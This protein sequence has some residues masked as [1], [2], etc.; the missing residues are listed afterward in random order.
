MSLSAFDPAVAGYWIMM[1]V[2][3]IHEV[4]PVFRF[5]RCLK[6][7]VRFDEGALP[8]GIGFTGN[9]LGLFVLVPFRVDETQAVQQLSDPA[10]A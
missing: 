6:L 4:N 7:T 3:G 1:R 8:I 2:G 10:F 5:F 9:Q